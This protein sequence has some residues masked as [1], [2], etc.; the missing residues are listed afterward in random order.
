MEPLAS[1][2]VE[3]ADSVSPAFGRHSLGRQSLGRHGLGRHRLGS[4]PGPGRRP[5]RRAGAAILGAALLWGTTGTA[6]TFAPH[7][8]SPLV[9][10]AAATGFGGLVLAATA[11]R[12][13]LRI[14]RERKGLP[15]LIAGALATAAYP[16][17]F[18]TSMNLAG[19]AVGVTATIGSSPLAAALIE[20]TLDAR[21]LTRRFI[22]ATFTAIAGVAL[23]GFSA[24]SN[25][26]AGHG[27][28]IVGVILG[29]GAGCLYGAYTFA[30]ARLID[31]NR[32][33]R[34]VMAAMFAPASAILLTIVAFAG[35]P[36]LRTARGIEVVSYLALIPIGLGYMLFGR[37]LRSTPASV[38]TALSL[39]EPVVAALVAEM[40]AHQ[41][42]AAL[43]WAGIALVATSIITLGV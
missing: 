16:L 26:G 2:R 23:L 32:P 28:V 5:D 40:V 12:R 42:V 33:S 10:G 24:A 6:A 34:D 19:V 14:L 22:G 4:V 36:L 3:D 31:D 20:F 21:R 11:G 1:H 25:R 13:I 35:G 18:Y 38:A 9:V 15:I 39:L 8:S 17:A 7:G 37:G 30:A 41:G 29:L 43:G 27:D